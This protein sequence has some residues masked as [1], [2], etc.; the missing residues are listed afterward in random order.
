MQAAVVHGA[1]GFDRGAEF[2]H[3]AFATDLSPAALARARATL[4]ASA[5]LSYDH[6]ARRAFDLLDKAPTPMPGSYGG[7]TGT[8]YLLF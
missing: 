4:L 2:F 3:C 8:P 6:G 5:R 1:F 7:I